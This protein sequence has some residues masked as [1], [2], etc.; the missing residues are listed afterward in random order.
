MDVLRIEDGLIIEIIT[1]DSEVIDW[2]GLPR[3]LEAS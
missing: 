1:F 3:Q 2:F